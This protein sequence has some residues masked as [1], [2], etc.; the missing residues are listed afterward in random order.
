MSTN[1]TFRDFST[2]IL[3]HKYTTCGFILKA[4]KPNILSK[5]HLSSQITFTF[6]KQSL[7]C[8]EVLCLVQL[9]L[10]HATIFLLKPQLQKKKK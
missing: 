10:T 6:T 5:L 2:T 9:K 8:K 3:V 1:I 4:N 7:R